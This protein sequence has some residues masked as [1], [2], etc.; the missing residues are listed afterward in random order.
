MLLVVVVA[1]SSQDDPRKTLPTTGLTAV[2]TAGPLPPTPEPSS[3]C[4]TLPSGRVSRTGSG[5]VVELNI[6]SGMP[7]PAWRLNHAEGA[8]LR[9]LLQMTQAELDVDGPDELGGFGVVADRT[10][11][12]FLRGLG[13]PS[14][15]WVQGD[16][17]V[18]AFLVE[19]IPCIS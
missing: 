15:F 2:V 5:F 1:C 10:A 9:R 18:T 3:P 12:G 16:D 4:G 7:N 11:V 14:R 17:E 6:M 19:T 8:K 13:L